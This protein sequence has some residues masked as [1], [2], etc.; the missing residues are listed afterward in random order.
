MQIPVS[1]SALNRPAFDRTVMLGLILLS[2][3]CYD[4]CYI[5]R[6]R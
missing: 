3:L 5:L 6:E 4:V 1:V 2:E